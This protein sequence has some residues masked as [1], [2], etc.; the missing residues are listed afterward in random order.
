MER[1]LRITQAPLSLIGAQIFET[2]GK[3]TCSIFTGH[4]C[5]RHIQN[6]SMD[7]DTRFAARM[8]LPKRKE[9]KDELSD[10]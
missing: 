6:Y 10:A 8:A 7:S 1:T 2:L 4:L 3:C 5:K 9:A